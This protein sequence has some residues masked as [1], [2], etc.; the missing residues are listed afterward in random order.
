MNKFVI[1]ALAAMALTV[2]AATRVAVIEL[3]A[4]GT[5]RRTTTASQFEETSVD[6]VASF[7]SALHGYGRK[8]QHAGMPVVPDLFSRPESG[9]VLGLTGSGVDLDH[10]PTL[11]GLL[12]N[13]DKQ[14]DNRVV[15]HM[16][17][18]GNQCKKMLD[19][20]QSKKDYAA[21]GSLKSVFE[22]QAQEAG[23]SGMH[24][25]V[26]SANAAD[27]DGQLASLISDYSSHKT[28]VLHLVVEEEDGSARRR[29]LASQLNGKQENGA[30][31]ATT[32]QRRLEQEGEEEEDADMQNQ[33]NGYYGYGYFNS[34]GEWV[35]PYK[36]MFQIQYFNVV[37]WTSLG[38]VAVLF[39]SI[40]LMIYMPLMADTLLFGESARVAHD[41]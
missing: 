29:S 39:F 26:S 15:G 37:L 10:M 5:V 22:S 14:Q 19:N 33:N 9:V 11:N 27:I 40:Y 35:T 8:L 16:Q 32:T 6:G 25:D 31:G 3:G 30:R 1:A 28:V 36:T 18:S 34:Y 21:S 12:K 24:F 41:D 2:D 17:V 7:W 38:L 23:I 4:S 20:V 13:V